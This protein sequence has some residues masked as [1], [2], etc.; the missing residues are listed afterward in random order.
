[1]TLVW[2]KSSFKTIMGAFG[3]NIFFS[4]KFRLLLTTSLGSFLIPPSF[5]R[6]SQEAFF[7][8]AADPPSPSSCFTSSL[9]S[10]FVTSFISTSLAATSSAFTVSVSSLVALVLLR[11][12]SWYVLYG[13]FNFSSHKHKFGI[14]VLEG[15]V[16]Q[17]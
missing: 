12:P 6:F 5:D 17:I 11:E 2:P 13:I 15:V 14:L 7:L 16:S 4:L 8:S 10:V 3:V 9:Y 1:M